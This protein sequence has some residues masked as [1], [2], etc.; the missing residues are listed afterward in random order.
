MRPGAQHSSSR[1][2]P[3][4][5]RPDTTTPSPT[6]PSTTTPSPTRPEHY[7]ALP[8]QTQ[9]YDALPDQT[10][11]API[12]GTPPNSSD[13]SV[14]TPALAGAT[15]ASVQRRRLPVLKLLVAAVVGLYLL[16]TV[17]WGID[18]AGHQGQAM[19][20]VHLAAVDVGGSNRDQ[21]NATVGELTD[22]LAARPL[23]INIGETSV[24]SDPVSL[25]AGLDAATMVDEAL[26]A[27]RDGLFFLRPLSWVGNFFSDYTV[28]PSYSVDGETAVDAT[29]TLIEP[30]LDQPVEPTLQLQGEKMTVAPGSPGEAIDPQDIVAQLP[31]VIEGGEPYRLELEAQV[32]EPELETSVVVALADEINRQTDQPISVQV[33]DDE[34]EVPSSVQKA[35][36]DLVVEGGAAR[37]VVVEERALQDLKPLFP[38]LGSEDQQARFSIV[39]GEPVIIP[40]SESVV[41]CAAGSGELLQAAIEGDVPASAGDAESSDDE[42]AQALRS[43]TLEPIITDRDEGVAE[44]ESL[45]IIEEVSSF[46]TEHACCQNRV[47]NI[48]RFADLMQGVIIRPGEEFSLNGFVG[49]RTTEKGFVADG[50]IARGNF[51]Q[52]VGGGISQYATTFFNAAFFAGVEFVEYQSHSIYISRYP[53]GREATIS[54]TK[55]DLKIRNNTDYGI[56]VWNEYTPTSITVNFYSTKHL[57]VE[58]LPLKRSSNRQCRIDITPRRI[59]Y[60]DGSQ[61]ED[62][63]FAT[64]RP[65]E[66]LDCNGNSTD[67]EEEDEP[68]TTNQTTPTTQPPPAPAPTP[69]TTPAPAPAP[70]PDPD[71][72]VLPPPG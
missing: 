28:E 20:G 58:A 32:T 12:T 16:V 48:Q 57:T 1:A 60:P 43:A 36:I 64:Y 4:S 13:P 17:A 66:G 53:R 68:P 63:V 23:E 21:L 72:E 9:H 62:Q 14:A 44:L 49:Q 3:S 7:D 52:Q 42:E 31:A 15:M 59:T 19:R 45:G 47:I 11:E 51:E 37:W 8:D 2:T 70:E 61:T 35:W 69:T 34:A 33:L 6:R 10:E 46:T 41:C 39:D 40:A 5:T 71:P 18:M 25:G 56:L 26:Q 24:A 38:A 22:Q 30:A 65:G 29:A 55:P 50:A 54:W 27:R 67:P